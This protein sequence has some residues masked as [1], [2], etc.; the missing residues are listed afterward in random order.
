MFRECTSLVTPPALPATNLASDCYASMF[1]WCTA[2]TTCPSLPATT[3]YSYC[4]SA[5]FYWCTSL[6]TLPK[7]PAT[8]LPRIC[9]QQM[10]RNC[11]NIKLSTSQTWNY[12]TA[13]R[14]PTTWTGTLENTNALYDVFT[15][16]WWT[17]TWTPSINTTYY[18]SN[19]LV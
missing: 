10:F 8:T 5:M 15:N 7:L 2:L 4:Y 16:T 17:F 18:T 14:I 13:Y 1:Y 9:Y 6:T 3:L 19:T 12:Q 11:T